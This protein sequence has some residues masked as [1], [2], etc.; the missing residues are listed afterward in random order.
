MLGCSILIQK[1]KLRVNVFPE[2]QFNSKLFS[3]VNGFN[4][5]KLDE[6]LYKN[7]FKD[8]YNPY[9]FHRVH[10]NALL[11][12]DK[13]SIKHT[14]DFEQYHVEPGECLLIKH[15]Q[16]QS[17]SMNENTN[18][19][20]VLFSQDFLMQHY[21]KNTLN[22]FSKLLRG[23]Q[24]K[25]NSKVESERFIKSLQKISN[26]W[27]EDYVTGLISSLLSVFILSLLAKRKKPT[28]TIESQS[29]EIMHRFDQLIQTEFHNTRNAK[30]YAQW[31][32]ISYKQLNE[33]TKETSYMT[34]K[35][36]IDEFIIM[37]AKRS[38]VSTTLSMKE[39][40]YY[41]GFDEPTNFQK[42]FKKYNQETPLQFR[43]NHLIGID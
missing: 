3:K 16:I 32:Q 35:N 33:V 36:Y 30:D 25:F 12:I 29:H 5:L 43:N 4:L 42:F 20:L 26:E 31:L 10:F 28:Q 37:E 23:S 9:A 8:D 7:P 27:D 13:G 21:S 6:I 11:I 22:L 14:L 24:N 41:L 38:L 40:S 1:N 39:I 17:F 34:A 2:I 18:G 19:Y 15:N